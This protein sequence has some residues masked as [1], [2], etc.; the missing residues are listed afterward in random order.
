LEKNDG[1]N[2]ISTLPV[3]AGFGINA[4]RTMLFKSLNKRYMTMAI[5]RD[6]NDNKP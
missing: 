2:G 5:M 1:L 6:K 3:N 4:K